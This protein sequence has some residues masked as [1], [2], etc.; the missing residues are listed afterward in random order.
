MQLSGW[1]RFPRIEARLV[2][3][4]DAT[5]A[6]RL[7]RGERSL[8]A[9]GAGRAYGDAALNP[10]CTLSTLRCDR[11]LAFDPHS[12]RITA[13]AGLMLAELIEFALPRGFFPPVTP[14]TRLLTIGGMIAADVHGKN[15]H[16]DG[17]FGRHVEEILLLCAD[18]E[19]R[20]C[21]PQ[22]NPTLFWATVGGMGLTGIILE[23]TFRL[24]GAETP[25][26]RQE[27]LR[28]PDLESAMES[29]AASED[30]TYTVAWIDCLARGARL[31]RSLIYRGEHANAAEAPADP[32]R[33]GK[34]RGLPV[35]V[36]SW[37]LN[38]ASMAA[39]NEIY[40]RRGRPGTAFVPWNTYFYPLDAVGAWNRVYGR[41]GF[42]QYQFVVPREA[43]RSAL[44]TVLD[45]VARDGDASFLAVLKLFG[46]Q[47][48]GMMSFPTEGWTLAMDF[49]LRARTLNLMVELDAIVA[50]HGGRL[51]LAKDSRAGAE[52]MRAGYPRLGEFA[53]V[54]DTV[55][56]Q[57]RFSSLLSRRLGL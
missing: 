9:R 28:A 29:L 49:P 39:F 54:R 1:A 32:P 50:G 16:R 20:R 21:S 41:A 47:G 24:A 26:I 3:I 7:I 11:I 51:Y 42:A 34:Q 13:E 36:P 33:I 5:D 43:G 14:G 31:G 10:D 57:R 27:T 46:A 6:A 15:H 19:A 44:R 12:G 48:E 25:W 56:P 17:S 35:D 52:L 38:R 8:I 22:E 53:R 45:R 55:D 40:Y 4:R 37:T 30:W 23:A 2:S 18:G